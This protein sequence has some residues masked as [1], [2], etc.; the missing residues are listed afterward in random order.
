MRALMSKIRSALDDLFDVKND[1]P[2]LLFAG[3]VF[4]AGLGLVLTMPVGR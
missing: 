1:W 3:A 4:C 2:A